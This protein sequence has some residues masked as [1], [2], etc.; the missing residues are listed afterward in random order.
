MLSCVGKQ[1]QGISLLGRN[2]KPPV[3]MVAFLV[4]LVAGD[5]MIH[6]FLYW[7]VLDIYVS[8]VVKLLQVTFLGWTCQDSIDPQLMASP[9]VESVLVARKIV[10]NVRTQ[11]P[12]FLGACF[13]NHSFFCEKM[14][15]QH[16]QWM[17]EIRDRMTSP[18][19]CHEL[20]SNIVLYIYISHGVFVQ[21]LYN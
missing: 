15:L 21:Q 20:L 12:F 6:Y 10:T 19:K 13:G 1:M 16:W 5:S 11:Q 2:V 7:I 18:C 3:Q 14:D 8:A 4:L 17:E 9:L